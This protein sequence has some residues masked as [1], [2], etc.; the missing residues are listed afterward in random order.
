MYSWLSICIGTKH[1][2]INQMYI[3][4]STPPCKR[5]AWA[6]PPPTDADTL[7]GGWW[8]NGAGWI[9]TG[10]L[11]RMA[12]VWMCGFKVGRFGESTSSHRCAKQCGCTN[13]SWAS[14]T[15]AAAAP[16][17]CCPKSCLARLRW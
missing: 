9:G 6:R 13:V 5:A 1:L 7:Q 4:C 3:K 8:G 14:R 10:A 11:Q 16:R 17:F 12:C 15:M 2:H